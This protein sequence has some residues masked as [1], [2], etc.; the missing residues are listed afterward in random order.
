VKLAKILRLDF[1]PGNKDCGLLLLRLWIGLSMMLLHGWGKLTGFG[2]MSQKFMDFL[3]IG[4]TASLALAVFAE[5]FC[6][7]LIVIGLF[8]RF[9]ALSL[10]ITMAVAFF[11]AHGGV[12]KGERSGEMAFIYLA[13]YLTLLLGGPGRF[14]LDAKMGG[15][16]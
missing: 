13:T 5:F 3:G 6:S 11:L 12:L 7:L 2:T 9:A 8:T 14:S 1:L 16:V 15:K 10:A 4:S